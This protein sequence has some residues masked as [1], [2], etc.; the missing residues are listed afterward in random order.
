M[1]KWMSENYQKLY[2]KLWE[3]NIGTF[4]DFKRLV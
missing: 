4:R 3:K 2:L 1:S